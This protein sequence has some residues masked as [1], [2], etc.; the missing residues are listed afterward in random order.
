MYTLF[1]VVSKDCVVNGQCDLTKDN[2]FYTITD[3]WA[4]CDEYIY[5]KEIADH[6]EHFL[7]WCE[8]RK[9]NP[10]D[11]TIWEVYRQ[12]VIGDNCDYGIVSFNVSWKDMMGFLRMFQGCYPLGCSFDRQAE[13]VFFANKLKQAFQDVADES[14]TMEVDKESIV[15]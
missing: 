9:A 11:D 10:N 15:N 7:M 5:A 13:K 8:Q 1:A 14:V 6:M 4:D 2:K 12:T 3:C